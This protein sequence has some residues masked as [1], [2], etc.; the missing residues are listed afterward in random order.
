MALRTATE[1]AISLRYMLRCLGIPIPSDGSYPTHLFGD[2]LGVIQNASNPEADLKKKH[3]ALSF[4][5]VREAIAAGITAPYW[6]DGKQNGSDITIKQIGTTEFL[7]HCTN[8]FWKPK[9]RQK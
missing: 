9:H 1:E 8:L 2:N 4:H 7:D 3:V 6:L 5:F